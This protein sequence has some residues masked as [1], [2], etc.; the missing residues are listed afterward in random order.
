MSKKSKAKRLNLFK[1]GREAF[2]NPLDVQAIR[3][4]E[5]IDR[6]FAIGVVHTPRLKFTYRVDGQVFCTGSKHRHGGGLHNKLKDRPI[7]KPVQRRNS[8]QRNLKSEQA[9]KRV[10]NQ[11]LYKTLDTRRVIHKM[12]YKAGLV[13]ADNQL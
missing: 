13:R 9:H 7:A 10:D 8:K 1:Q 2:L 3:E 4:G 11:E 6:K 5:A 12:E